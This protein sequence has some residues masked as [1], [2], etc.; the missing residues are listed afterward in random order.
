MD[1]KKIFEKQRW[2]EKKQKYVRAKMTDKKLQAL[3]A[4]MIELSGRIGFKVSSRGWCYQL[5]SERLIN[6]GDFDRVQDAINRCRRKGFLP[7]DFVAED[8]ARQFSGVVETD[9]WAIDQ[10]A[11]TLAWKLGNFMTCGEDYNPYFWEDEQFYIQM[12]V[13]KI[14]LVTLFKPVCRRY[15]VPIA[16]TKGWSSI[17]QR[18]EYARRF[19]EAEERGLTCVLLYCG[20]LD[21]DGERISDTLRTNLEQVSEVTWRDNFTGYDP[22]DLIIERFGLSGE[23]V[24]KLGLTWIDNLQ[25]GSKGELAVQL[26]DGRIVA[27]KTKSG[28]RHPNFGLPYLTEYLKT[29]G[30][31]KCEANAI[32]PRPREARELCEEAINKYYDKGIIERFEGRQNMVAEKFDKVLRDVDVKEDLEEII[33]KLQRYSNENE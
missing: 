24:N 20:D 21:P 4:L 9:F 23:T 19:K 31:R 25:T 12:I 3:A 18:A 28:K 2:D 11:D 8:S 32:V 26:S 5:E 6:K 10:P 27:G 30:V 22:S 29:Y 1:S 16:N 13:E 33:E 17:L 15:K 14:D 7:V